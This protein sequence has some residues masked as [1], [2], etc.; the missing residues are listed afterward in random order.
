MVELQF[1]HPNAVQVDSKLRLLGDSK[2]SGQVV[3]AVN[4]VSVKSYS[5]LA[6]IMERLVQ[7]NAPVRIA[8]KAK[9]MSRRDV[10]W[11][12]AREKEKV[13]K[14]L[15][16]VDST[17]CGVLHQQVVEQPPDIEHRRCPLAHRLEGSV[18]GQCDEC[19]SIANGLGC[20]ICDY[21]VCWACAPQ[22]QPR[23]PRRRV[24]IAPTPH[25]P[26]TSPAPRIR[27]H[28]A[29][30][31][32]V[33]NGKGGKGGGG[34]GGRGGGVGGGKYFAENSDASTHPSSVRHYRFGR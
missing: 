7:Q 14:L 22:P 33:Y 34:G 1:R 13:A 25:T 8:L 17:G 28:P 5:E 26:H 2:W 30:T 12:F 10:D 29:S 27:P 4:G 20:R 19:G 9:K 23:Q 24:S 32:V 6:Q 18:G 11:Q 16:T 21:D 31:A 3:Q 15:R